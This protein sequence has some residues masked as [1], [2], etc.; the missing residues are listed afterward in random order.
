MSRVAD[1]LRA[2]KTSPALELIGAAAAMLPLVSAR[3]LLFGAQERNQSIFDFKEVS[4]GFVGIW[5]INKRKIGMDATQITTDLVNFVNEL[6][7]DIYQT[8]I[9]TYHIKHEM[10][11][12]LTIAQPKPYPPATRELLN[13]IQQL[14]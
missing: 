9:N 2:A 7:E 3:A 11:H 13:I 6:P 5:Y 4:R 8:S 10:Q 1:D 12:W 14:R